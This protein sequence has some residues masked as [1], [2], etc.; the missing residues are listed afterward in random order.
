MEIIEGSKSDSSIPPGQKFC[1]KP[2]KAADTEKRLHKRIVNKE[3]IH[4]GKEYCGKKL[5]RDSVQ[6]IVELTPM[7][8]GLCL[9]FTNSAST[10]YHI[11]CA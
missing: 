5:S 8:E 6:D 3:N 7:Q 1:S 4:N 10:H 11:N 9:I 2:E